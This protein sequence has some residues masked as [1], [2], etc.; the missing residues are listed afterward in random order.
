M[1]NYHH[2]GAFASQEDCQD[3]RATDQQWEDTEAKEEVF[4]DAPYYEGSA[5][6]VFVDLSQSNQI[7]AYEGRI[8]GIYQT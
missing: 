5:V 7:M 4:L 3:A 8:L 1:H 2:C 6:L